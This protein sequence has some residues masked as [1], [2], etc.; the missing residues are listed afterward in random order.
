[1]TRLFE[2]ETPS[3]EEERLEL[4]GRWR[5]EELVEDAFFD[6]I[7]ATAARICDAP[8]GLVSIITR[9]RQC[10]VG[11]FGFEQ[12]TVPRESSICSHVM[13]N[14]RVMIVEDTRE[15]VVFANTS[16]VTVSPDIR[17][18][19]G[20]PL[21]IDNRI[22]VGALSII[23]TKPRRLT[24]EERAGLMEI[25]HQVEQKLNAAVAGIENA[26]TSDTDSVLFHK[27]FLGSYLMK[28]LRRH[29]A[30]SL[31]D[32]ERLGN[33]G[34]DSSP[35]ESL[36][37][38]LHWTLATIDRLAESTQAILDDSDGRLRSK[39]PVCIGD[40]I[41]QAREHFTHQLQAR[42]ARFEVIHEVDEDAVFGDATLLADVMTRVIE[43]TLRTS[44][45]GTDIDVVIGARQQHLT[46]RITSEGELPPEPFRSR[47]LASEQSLE[48]DTEIDFDFDPD[49]E[50]TSTLKLC[51]MIIKAHDGTIALEEE[52]PGVRS[53]VVTLPAASR[54]RTLELH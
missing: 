20:I 12:A 21:L 43:L 39:A 4:I 45:S 54:D 41:D 53:I 22:A 42:S 5:L 28:T 44:V 27:T 47:I 31:A 25:V 46:L 18:Y 35:E 10:N 1:M 49:F 9:D 8:T 40:L 15:D 36:L 24:I 13:T 50:W 30:F 6:A 37:R 17:F 52:R 38:E 2:V 23:D 29:V 16:P 48:G 34:A 11:K 19:V 14:R 33:E 26:P 32:V 7:A 3:T 51:A